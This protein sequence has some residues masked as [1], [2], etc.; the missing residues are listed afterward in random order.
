MC[1]IVTHEGYIALAEKLN[2]I[3]PVRGTIKKTM[4][5]NSGAEA[6]ENAV[7]MAKAYTKRLILLY[8]QELFMEEQA[9]Q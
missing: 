5:V 3:V 9:L 4:F 6:D 2:E 1:N 7:K 8:F